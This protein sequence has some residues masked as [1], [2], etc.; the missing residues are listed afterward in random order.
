MADDRLLSAVSLP[1][2]HT[3]GGSLSSSCAVTPSPPTPCP[4]PVASEHVLR[5]QLQHAFPG[6]ARHEPERS[7]RWI[8]VRAAPVG[9]I[10]RVECFGAEFDPAAAANRHD[11]AHADVESPG[12]RIA[13]RIARL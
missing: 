5:R 13:Q 6:L 3:P 11:L 4:A 10:E 9:M 12:I 2:R 8:V 1:T 7:R